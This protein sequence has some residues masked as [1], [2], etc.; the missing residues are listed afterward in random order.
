VSAVETRTP[1]L[2]EE[3]E[4][5]V[6]SPGDD[7]ALREAVARLATAAGES[8]DGLVFFGSRRTGAAR[9]NAWSAY[10]LF[11]I[12]GAY[13]PFYAAMAAAGLSGKSPGPLAALSCWLP[14]TQYSIRFRDPDVHLKTAVI[15]TDT[16]HR[17]TSPRRTD[18][19]CIGRLFQPSRLVFARTDALRD[20]LVG[21]LVSAHALTWDWVRP[22]LPPAF[23]AAV[24]GATA[25]SVSMS[26]EVR[27]EPAGRAQA[28]WRAQEAEQVPVFEA[29][30]HD[31]AGRGQI[32]RDPGDAGWSVAEPATWREREGLKLYFRRSIARAT[33]RWLKHM[34]S[35]E[36]WLEYIV[37][38]VSRH[39][40]QKIELTERERRWPWIFAWGRVWRYLRTKD[41]RRGGG[42]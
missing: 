9:A 30:L 25:L 5:R 13:R 35:F 8:L 10:D 18:H 20:A 1:T 29:L 3:V 28:L 12:V 26:W 36:G 11:V 7:P 40:G 6:L 27:P 17:E 37:Q 34:L 33:T 41:E 23:D 4:R 24:Y 16:F 21:D 15:R 2:R 14:P 42:A 22:W 31:L 32:V 39:S 38:K 19:F